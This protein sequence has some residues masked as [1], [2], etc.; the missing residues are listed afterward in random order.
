MLGGECPLGTAGHWE[1]CWQIP[2][3]IIS[4]IGSI[5]FAITWCHRGIVCNV[6]DLDMLGRESGKRSFVKE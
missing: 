2:A 3:H 1:S 6:Y 5:R 4:L